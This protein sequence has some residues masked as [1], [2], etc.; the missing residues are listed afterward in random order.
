MTRL[1]APEGGLADASYLSPRTDVYNMEI[2][3]IVMMM[4]GR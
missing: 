2:H 1:E 4:V 3:S